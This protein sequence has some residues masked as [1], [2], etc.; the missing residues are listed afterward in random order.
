MKDSE[1]NM[2]Q[3][4]S[5]DAGQHT[6][7]GT[8]KSQMAQSLH[9][10]FRSLPSFSSSSSSRTL[11]FFAGGKEGA[12]LIINYLPALPR[13]GIA[14]TS[15]SRGQGPVSPSFHPPSLTPALPVVRRFI[16]YVHADEEQCE[17]WGSVSPGCRHSSYSRGGT[18]LGATRRAASRSGAGWP[19]SPRDEAVMIDT[20]LRPETLTYISKL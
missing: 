6:V 13:K 16:S 3:Y 1:H 9:S 15:R 10:V 7:S 18:H 12:R 4:E 14:I 5:K 17:N 19:A 8:H 20:L 2:R 11:S